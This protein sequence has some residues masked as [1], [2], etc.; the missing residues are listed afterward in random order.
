MTC[1][2]RNQ[3]V[4]ESWSGSIHPISL[5]GV[6]PRTGCL[7]QQHTYTSRYY[8]ALTAGH[9]KPFGTPWCL[10]VP[11]N[12]T[13]VNCAFYARSKY[14]HGFYTILRIK[15]DYFLK[16]H[17]STDPCDSDALSWGMNWI[18][19]GYYYSDDLQDSKGWHIVTS[20]RPRVLC[21]TP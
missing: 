2:I 15:G 4:C 19:I 1:T 3:W 12:V 9:I 17:S 11:H 14:I 13:F 8:S 5:D 7:L 18:W 16:Q 6:S 21:K 10:Y 20:S